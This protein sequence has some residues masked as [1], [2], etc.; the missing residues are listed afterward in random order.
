MAVVVGGIGALVWSLRKRV[1]V[2]VGWGD[3]SDP[4]FDIIDPANEEAAEPG[5]EDTAAEEVADSDSASP[6]DEDPPRP[7]DAADGAG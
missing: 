7:A 5:V 6:D 2:A 4:C 1:R 3:Q